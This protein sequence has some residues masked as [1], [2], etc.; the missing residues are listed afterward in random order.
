MATAQ[1]APRRWSTG[2]LRALEYVAYPAA[3]GAAGTILSLGVI[4][5]LPALAATAYGLQ[6][7]RRDGTTRVFGEVFRGWRRYRRVLLPHS[8]L[9][10]VAALLLAANLW[11]L[12]GRTGLAAFALF[13]GQVGIAVLAVLYHL[14]L[15]VCA[16][17]RPN[18]GAAAWR[19]AAAVLAFARPS[20]G[21]GLLATAVAATIL[22]VVVPVGPLLFGASVPLLYGLYLA[23]HDDPDPAADDR[24]APRAA[25]PAPADPARRRGETV[26]PDPPAGRRSAAPADPA[27]RRGETVHPDPPAGRRS[28]A[29]ADPARRGTRR[30][31]R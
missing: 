12:S 29:P 30:G 25:A 17:R 27:R 16:G 21:L 13:A 20:R 11:F 8:A 14:A 23:D 3:A 19:R 2:L 22:T 5:W 4:T 10:T 26:H 15:A 31:T 18:D 6:A 1:R 9:G 7:W 28:A 24:P